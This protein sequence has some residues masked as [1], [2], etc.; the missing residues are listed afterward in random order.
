MLIS[1]LKFPRDSSTTAVITRLYPLVGPLLSNGKRDL[2]PMLMSYLLFQFHTP[3]FIASQDVY[4]RTQLRLQSE[5]L[6]QATL[7]KDVPSE[8][9]RPTKNN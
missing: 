5:P 7:V 8:H 3:Q 4:T 9:L 2:D 6:V 1:Y